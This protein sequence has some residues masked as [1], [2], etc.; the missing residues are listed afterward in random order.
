ML[1]YRVVSLPLDDMLARYM[2]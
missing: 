1:N 2:R